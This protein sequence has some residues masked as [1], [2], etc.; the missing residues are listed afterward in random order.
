MR[1]RGVNP[2]EMLG[3]RVARAARLPMVG[4]LR[5]VRQPQ[6]QAA[7]SQDGRAANLRDSMSFNAPRGQGG[8]LIIFDDVVTTGAT[9]LEAARAIRAAPGAPLVAGFCVFA[10]TLRKRSPDEP[11]GS[12]FSPQA[13]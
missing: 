2:A 8:P 13:K 9:I 7:L 3:R 5:L 4:G 10:E 1:R 6:D 11:K 12:M